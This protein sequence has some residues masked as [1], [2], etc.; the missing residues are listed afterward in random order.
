MKSK[1]PFIIG[2][3]GFASVF[4]VIS[5]LGNNDQPSVAEKL[6]LI[7]TKEQNEERIEEAYQII[8]YAHS[9][10]DELSGLLMFLL[11]VIFMLSC[12]IVVAPRKSKAEPAGI[13]NDEAAPPRD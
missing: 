5:K 1:I 6:R 8:S 12:Y 3:L 13:V 7:Q 2:T 11:G 9:K 10:L 4:F